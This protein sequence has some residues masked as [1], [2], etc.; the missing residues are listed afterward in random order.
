MRKQTQVK[1]V[2]TVKRNMQGESWVPLRL[3]DTYERVHTLP[4]CGGCGGNSGRISRSKWHGMDS[5]TTWQ[6]AGS[7]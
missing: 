5:S 4:V 1:M 2:N 3:G 7:R 6:Y